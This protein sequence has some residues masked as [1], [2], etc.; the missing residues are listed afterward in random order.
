MKIIL[1]G[2]GCGTQATM[3]QAVAS[4][5]AQADLIIG[6]PRL[7]RGL[8]GSSARL[9]SAISPDEILRLIESISPSRC[10]VVFSGDTGFYSG[11]KSLIPLLEAHGIESEV[12]PGISSVAFFAAALGRPWQDWVLCSAHGVPCDPVSAVMC[13]RPVCF[14]TGGNQGPDGLCRTLCDAGLSAL[15]VIV[16]ENLSYP[17]QRIHS[18]T[19]L[20][21]SRQHFAPLSI[22]LTEA[23]PRYPRR[24]AGFPDDLFLREQVPMTKQLVRASI[25]ALLAP[26]QEDICWDVGSGTGSVSVELS[27]HAKRVYAV[28]RRPQAAALTRKNREI[29]CCWNMS[30]LEGSAPDCLHQLPPPDKVF[31]GGSGGALAEIVE[32]AISRNPRVRIL[33][34]AIALETL[35]QTRHSLQQAGCVVSVHQLSVSRSDSVAGLTMMRGENPIFLIVGQ[36]P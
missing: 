20:E 34:S 29:F 24:A 7:L 10:C 5:L 6:A 2:V 13:G 21:A 35:E 17:Q 31:I 18:M 15:P 27:L 36:R 4:A 33:V 23:A 1:A 12:L 8:S 30:V 26:E 14:L 11:A 16:G 25:L 32:T 3:T 22:L 19:A 9:E 28:E